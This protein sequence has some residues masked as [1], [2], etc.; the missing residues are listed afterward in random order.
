MKK[1]KHKNKAYHFENDA[2]PYGGDIEWYECM[3][4]GKTFDEKYKTYP[5]G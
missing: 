1:C 2:Y 3:K 4:C 5:N